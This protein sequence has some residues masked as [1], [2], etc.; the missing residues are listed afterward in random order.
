[1][2]W[3][4]RFVSREG[5]LEH[6]GKPLS[7]ETF[8]PCASGLEGPEVT[9]GARVLLRYKAPALFGSLT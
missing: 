8:E 7:W 5:G 4:E 9:R 1:M 6:E 2:P 3:A